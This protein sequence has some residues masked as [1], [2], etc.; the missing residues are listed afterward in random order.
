MLIL[1][2]VLFLRGCWLGGIAPLAGM[3][4]ALPSQIDY[5]TQRSGQ[6]TASFD[7]RC[8]EVR[9]ATLAAI[10]SHNS[11]AYGSWAPKPS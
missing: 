6:L 2:L 7:F 3:A 8:P 5:N 4:S 1:E 10:R 9:A 11:E